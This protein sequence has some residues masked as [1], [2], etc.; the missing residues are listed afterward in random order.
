MNP[1][2]C[3][4][5]VNPELL[6]VRFY[7]VVHQLLGGFVHSV[8]ALAACCAASRV[9]NTPTRCSPPRV[10]HSERGANGFNAAVITPTPLY[11][12]GSRAS[13]KADA[14]LARAGELGKYE[15]ASKSC[16]SQIVAA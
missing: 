9:G 3:R 7:G 12:K 5:S 1:V 2:L 13:S 8:L 11:R 4:L 10:K 15:E 14:N 16:Q 6:H